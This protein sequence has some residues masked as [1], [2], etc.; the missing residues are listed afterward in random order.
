VRFARSISTFAASFAVAALAAGSPSCSNSSDN[1]GGDGGD[2][3]MSAI[4]LDSTLP[5]GDASTCD[6]CQSVCDCQPGDTFYNPARCGNEVCGANGRWGGV[7]CTVGPGCPACDPCVQ[8][9][10]CTFTETVFNDAACIIEVCPQTGMW[11][12]WDCTG[13]GCPPEA[14][15]DGGDAS[16]PMGDA[17]SGDASLDG[18]SDAAEGG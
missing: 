11:G 2:D 17:Q 13:S 15:V 10:P 9:C 6:P 3:G 16:E 12:D 1:G 8:M 18:G 4:N 5:P 14:G 7:S